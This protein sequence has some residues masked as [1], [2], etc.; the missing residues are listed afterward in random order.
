MKI[1]SDPL[2]ASRLA[3]SP[4]FSGTPG[5]LKLGTTL[6]VKGHGQVRIRPIRLE[7]EQEIVRFHARISE[8]SVYLR[9]FEYLG[10]DQRT[11]HERLV[12]ICT[13]TPDFYAVVVEKPAASHH[14]A[15][16]VAVGRLTRTEEPGV[17]AF[18]TLI[19]DEKERT[20]LP[21]LLLERLVKLARGFGFKRLMGESLVVD[22]ERVK[23]CRAL[24]FSL[25]TKPEDGVVCA[26]LDL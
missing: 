23:V 12:R 18:D 15:T 22:H 14:P 11:S 3:R 17:A 8:E 1:I 13:N 16:I 5:R 25:R 7:D 4:D 6:T 20:Q 9:Y 2:P 19:V 10:L 24:G 21:R 26:T